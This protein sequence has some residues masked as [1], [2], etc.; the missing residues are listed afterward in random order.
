M[1]TAITGPDFVDRGGVAG[2][3]NGLVDENDWGYWVAFDYGR[4]VENSNWRLPAAGTMRDINGSVKR[5]SFGK[6]ELY[7]LDAIKTRTHTA[8]FVTTI[9]SKMS[10]RFLC[11]YRT[12]II[13]IIYFETKKYNV[14]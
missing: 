4:W 11:L 7:Y 10:C 3:A 6:K 14:I 2:A 12:Y 9:D 1:L 13:S 5:Y 8:L